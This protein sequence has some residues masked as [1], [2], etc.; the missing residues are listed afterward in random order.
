MLPLA[1][2]ERLRRKREREDMHKEKIYKMTNKNIFCILIGFFKLENE[3]L[4][5]TSLARSPIIRYIG[6]RIINEVFY[7]GSIGQKSCIVLLLQRNLCWCVC[8]LIQEEK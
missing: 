2:R 1:L 6:K 7:L 3:L 4:H 8:I 5:V